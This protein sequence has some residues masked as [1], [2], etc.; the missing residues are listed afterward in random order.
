MNIAV[1]SAGN[2]AVLDVSGEVDLYHSPTLLGKL[3]ELI[4]QDQKR[5]LLNF[6]S[7][8]YIDSSGLAT[9]IGAY[10]QLRPQGGQLRLANVSKNVLNVFAVAR[11]DKV[12]SIHPTEIEALQ[13]LGAS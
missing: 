6:Q 8:T 4:K 10:Q 11:L 12:F 9:L 1:R 2:V 7:V 13:A 3:T 5:I